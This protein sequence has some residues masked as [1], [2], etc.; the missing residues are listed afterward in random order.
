L[1][2]WR[3]SFIIAAIFG[4][5]AM[6]I[7]LVFMFKYKNHMKAPHITAGLSVENLIMFLLATPV[8][9]RMSFFFR[10]FFL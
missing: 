3:N 5:P 7:M 10:F 2:R 8:Q 4:V 9:V 1:N 6:V